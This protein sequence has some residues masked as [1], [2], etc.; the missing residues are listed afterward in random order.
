MFRSYAPDVRVEFRDAEW[1]I[2]CV[3]R[4]SDGSELRSC[5]V[6]ADL[7][8]T[9]HQNYQLKRRCRSVWGADLKAVWER[10]LYAGVDV[11]EGEK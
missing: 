10:K 7:P 5:L 6:D 11:F 9:S 3:D 4:P 8:H 1:C 2:K